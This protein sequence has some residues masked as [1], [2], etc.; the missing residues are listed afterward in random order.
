MFPE[1]LIVIPIT[2]SNKVLL[3]PR[4]GI[5]ISSS[6]KLT[7]DWPISPS[8]NYS[9]WTRLMQPWEP[10]C[11]VHKV[12][13]FWCP[14]PPQPLSWD[15]HLWIFHRREDLMFAASFVVSV[16]SSCGKVI[17]LL[18]IVHWPTHPLYFSFHSGFVADLHHECHCP[19]KA[20]FH[21]NFLCFVIVFMHAKY[22]IWFYLL[23]EISVTTTVVTFIIYWLSEWATCMFTHTANCENLNNSHYSVWELHQLLC[24]MFRSAQR[25]SRCTFIILLPH[26]LSHLHSFLFQLYSEFWNKT[27]E[28]MLYSDNHY[29]IT[30]QVGNTCNPLWSAFIPI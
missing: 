13:V 28:I 8:K 1:R 4:S 27:S 23:S 3:V 24:F 25:F 19:C 18:P 16:C 7:A 29:I 10:L 12:S 26:D 11:S 9:T 21:S 14:P 5:N 15:Q 17:C 2:Y 22:S 30:N 6:N 20:I